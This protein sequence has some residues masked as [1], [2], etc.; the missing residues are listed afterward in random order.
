MLLRKHVSALQRGDLQPLGSKVLGL[1]N[2]TVLL[3]ELLMSA[4]V[5]TR[6]EPTYQQ[7]IRDW[8]SMMIT[9][10]TGIV[11]VAFGYY[12]GSISVQRYIHFLSGTKP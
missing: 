7:P 2:G 10:W 11:S 1:F 8:N 6:S 9:A 12:F 4:M 3:S 5:I